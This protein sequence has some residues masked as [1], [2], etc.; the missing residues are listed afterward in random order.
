MIDTQTIN[1]IQSIVDSGIGIEDASKAQGISIAGLRSA[2]K[3]LGIP[4]PKKKQLVNR[5]IPYTNDYQ[6][7]LITQAELALKLGVTQAAICK[8]L[9]QLPTTDK[10]KARQKKY[11]AVLDYIREHGGYVTKALKALGLKTNAQLIRDYAKEVGFNLSHYQFAHRRYGMWLTLPGPFVRQPP[12]SYLVPAVCLSCGTKYDNVSLNN[13]CSGKS[14]MCSCCHK[15]VDRVHYQVISIKDGA[16][17]KSIMDW[18]KQL[19]LFDQYQKLRIRLLE[20]KVV[21]IDGVDYQLASH[22]TNE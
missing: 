16:V 7:G 5:L 1:K 9:K 21:T 4:Y 20:N 15:N 22:T 12:S 14:T 6:C 13:L 10:V 18:A 11:K 8:A 19:G 17:F 3:R 2:C